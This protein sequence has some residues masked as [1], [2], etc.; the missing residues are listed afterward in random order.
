[1]EFGNNVGGA[2]GLAITIRLADLYFGV[3]ARASAR[4]RMGMSGMHPARECPAVD[5]LAGVHGL[6]GHATRMARRASGLHGGWRQLGAMARRLEDCRV[7]PVAAPPS[8]SHPAALH[9]LAATTAELGASGRP[10]GRPAQLRVRRAAPAT[11]PSPQATRT[12]APGVHPNG[13][14]ARRAG[15]CA[16]VHEHARHAGA[17]RRR[18]TQARNAVR[19][20]ARVA[21]TARTERY[22]GPARAPCARCCKDVPVMRTAR[23]ATAAPRSGTHGVHGGI[24][25]SS[26]SL[27]LPPSL[28]SNL[29]GAPGV[30][31][32]AAAQVS[33][34]NRPECTGQTRPAADAAPKSPRRIRRAVARAPGVHAAPPPRRP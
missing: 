4:R 26:I 23:A 1:M 33:G 32:R 21:H 13:R 29:L 25:V 18:G 27:S 12:C 9:P 8:T 3:D 6:R 14:H 2:A 7:H 34:L 10:A 24:A 19:A 5:A 22:T 20:L 28:S 15:C 16:G 30:H 17:A 11:A 31:T